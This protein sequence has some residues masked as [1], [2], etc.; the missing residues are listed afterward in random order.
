MPGGVGPGWPSAVIS[1]PSS[2]SWLRCVA[3]LK[4]AKRFDFVVEQLDAHR[5]QPVGGENV[6]DSAAM[7]ELARQFDGTR[8]MKAALDQ[9]AQQ[10]LDVD[11]LALAQRSGR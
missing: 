8:G 7:R 5:Q 10:F 4:R 9:P 2:V 3:D 11:P 1:M 6:D